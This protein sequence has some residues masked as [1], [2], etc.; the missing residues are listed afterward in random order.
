MEHKPDTIK[1]SASHKEEVFATHADLHVTVKGSSLLS[2]NEAM[3]KAKEVNQL[4]E[5]LKQVGVKEEAVTLQGVNVSTSSGAVL[6]SSTASYRLK[7]RCEDLAKF[8]EILDVI[9][10]QKNAT[11]T[12]T[13]WKYDEDA[14]REALLLTT[15]EK[16]KS[17]AAKIAQAMGVKLLGVYDLMENTYDEELAMPFQAQA[18]A[19]FRSAPAEPEPSLGMDV[20][21]SK[22]IHVNVDIWYRVSE[23]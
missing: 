8:A 22:T 21:H 3:K 7:I 18:K 6:K 23:F 5:A 9:S 11:L 13:E 16:A 4:L 17:K 10:S 1:V 12:Q 2:S 15:L 14:A 19:A 20:Q